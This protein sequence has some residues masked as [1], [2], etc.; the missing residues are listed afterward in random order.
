V[1]TLFRPKITTYQ[2]PDGRFR[3][4]DGKQATSETPGAAKVESVSKKQE[5]ELRDAR[6]T[7]KRRPSRSLERPSRAAAQ[8]REPPKA[9]CR[10]GCSSPLRQ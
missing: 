5:A 6:V 4:P 2:F 9:A 3:T 1:A 7:G 10:T 8:G